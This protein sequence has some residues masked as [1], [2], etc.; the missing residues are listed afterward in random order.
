MEI[1]NLFFRLQ[2]KVSFRKEDAL[3]N[4]GL[5]DER[6]Q[7]LHQTT[8]GLGPEFQTGSSSDEQGGRQR[9]WAP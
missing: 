5:Q 7:L 1:N 8:L 3:Q 4:D 2:T 9:E 6:P